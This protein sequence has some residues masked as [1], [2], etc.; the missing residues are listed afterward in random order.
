MAYNEG[1]KSFTAAGTIKAHARVKL[2]AGT[3]TT[4]PEVEE[5]G[6]GEN[7][8]GFAEYA[9]VLG[10]M[11]SIKLKNYPGTVEAI[12]SEA[13]LIGATLY[14]AAAGRVGDTAVGAGQAIA[15]EAATALGDIVEVLPCF[16]L[17]D[18]T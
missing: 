3:T 8:I 11:V 1:V 6:A 9:A 14:G 16:D 7:Y 18:N 12:A 2:S 15:I 5:A 10:D 13:F 4:P 17:T